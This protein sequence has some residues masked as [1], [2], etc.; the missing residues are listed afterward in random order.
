METVYPSE[1]PLDNVQ[2]VSKLHPV[3]H[4][5]RT[6]PSAR[7]ITIAGWTVTST[8]LPICSSADCDRLAAKLEIPVPE[9]TFGN[10]SVSIQGPKGWKCDFDSQHALAAVDKTGSQGIKVSYSEQWNR[11]R[12]TICSTCSQLAGQGIAKTSEG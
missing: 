12:Y 1:L 2:T 7:S 10:N 6:T 5:L 9:M 4:E 11:T 3:P 8:K